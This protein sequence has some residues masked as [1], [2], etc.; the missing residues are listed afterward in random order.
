MG[1]MSE[2]WRATF[3]ALKCHLSAS[4]RTPSMSKMTAL[5]KVF[6]PRTSAERVERRQILDV[7][8]VQRVARRTQEGAGV[9][10]GVPGARLV[11]EHE[12]AGG[13]VG[14]DVELDREP[15]GHGRAD[16]RAPVLGVGVG[17]VQERTMG[18]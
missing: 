1:S 12:R 8:G 10:V 4:T 11:G 7:Q 9:A 6:L 5:I 3:R 17:P 18:K 16:A 2:C 14:G 15:V 13:R